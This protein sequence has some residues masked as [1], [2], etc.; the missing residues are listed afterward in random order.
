MGQGLGDLGRIKEDSLRSGEVMRLN[1]ADDYQSSSKHTCQD[2]LVQQKRALTADFPSA[3]T[4]LGFDNIS[5][6][7]N[8]IIS[9]EG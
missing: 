2:P 5:S 4:S 9:S 6:N 8:A 3:D 7:E 1:I